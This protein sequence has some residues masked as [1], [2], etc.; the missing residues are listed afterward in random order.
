[1]AGIPQSQGAG[2][3][4]L[5]GLTSHQGSAG[6]KQHGWWWGLSDADARSAAVKDWYNV[7]DKIPASSWSVEPPQEWR[8]TGGG[9]SGGGCLGGLQ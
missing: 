3:S 8:K 4:P 1:M 2:G 5:S 7:P 6:P 9:N